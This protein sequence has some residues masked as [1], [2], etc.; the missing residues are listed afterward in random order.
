MG[1]WRPPRSL[2]PSHN[3][4]VTAAAPPW[5]FSVTVAIVRL[6]GIHLTYPTYP[7]TRH[8][9]GR[10]GKTPENKHFRRPDLSGAATRHTRQPDTAPRAAGRLVGSTRRRRV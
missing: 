5:V 10:R 2:S 4:Q 6:P 7:T 3:R 1:H 8:Q 9:R